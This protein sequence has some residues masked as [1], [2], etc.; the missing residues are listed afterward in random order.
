MTI[1]SCGAVGRLVEYADAEDT[2]IE[3][4]ELPVKA[5]VL[6]GLRFSS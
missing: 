5:R 3:P 1:H 6:G 2:Q 4:R